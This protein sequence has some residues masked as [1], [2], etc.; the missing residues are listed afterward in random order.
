MALHSSPKYSGALNNTAPG[1]KPP[2]HPAL[3]YLS[4]Y[5][6]PLREQARQWLQQDK[7]EPWLLDKHP[8]PHDL[9][10]DKA[11][12]G[13]V[14][15]LRSR[16]MRNA[17]QLQKV[18]YDSKLHV[19]HN[20]LGLH[21]RKAQVHGS[22]INTRHEIRI[23]ALFKQTPEAFLRMI[24]VHELAHLR[25]PEHDKAFYQLCTHMLPDYHQLEFELRLYLSWSEHA[26]RSL[27]Q[28]D[29]AATAGSG[30]TT[31]EQS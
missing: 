12:Y 4:A 31:A 14:A 7:L 27:W 6:A 10:T 8:Q 5:P 18:L 16:Y 19:V 26:G 25:E 22:R 24:V 21:T 17:A 9:R 3:P 20:A 29:Q 13:Y 2:C 15:E 1:G 28:P 30:T 23:A 11:L